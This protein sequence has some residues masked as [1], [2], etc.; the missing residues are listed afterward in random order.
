[1]A[2]STQLKGV[3]IILCLYFG[4]TYSP[5]GRWVLTSKNLVDGKIIDLSSYKN[6][7]IQQYRSQKAGPITTGILNCNSFYADGEAYYYFGTLNSITPSSTEFG[8]SAWVNISDE[9]SLDPLIVAIGLNV[10]SYGVAIDKGGKAHLHPGS[11]PLSSSLTPGTWMLMV[12]YWIK[13]ASLWTWKVIIP[14]IDAVTYSNAKNT[15]P[16]NY[17]FLGFSYS[18]LYFYEVQYF[19]KAT[20]NSFAVTL[21]DSSDSTYIATT[22]ACTN[23]CSNYCHPEKGCLKITCECPTYC[24]CSANDDVC[25]SCNDPNADIA[26]NCQC[27]AGYHLQGSSCVFIPPANCAVWISGTV[28]TQCNSDYFLYDNG[29]STTCLAC[30]NSCS[31]CSAT[32]SCFYCANSIVQDGN[33]CRVDS[34]GYQLSFSSPNIIVINFAH[35]LS[36]TLAIDNL[37]VTTMTNQDISTATWK[38]SNLSTPSK[39]QIITDLSVSK[40]PINLDFS[41]N[42]GS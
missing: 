12:Y 16:G 15:Y 22:S 11:I 24:T 14:G 10:Y 3:I 7:P 40:L 41:F 18:I 5:L 34:I 32:P 31:S 26:N 21:Y 25:T 27:K 20:V 30:A 1:M 39:Y 2:I 4:N 17:F 35:P 23:S 6:D 33:S 8:I 29:A 13:N 19:I 9:D 38:I 28:C 36:E 42:Q 37:K